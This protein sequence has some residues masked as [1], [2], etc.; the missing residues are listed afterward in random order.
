M[1]GEEG[2]GEGSLKGVNG[3]MEIEIETE[4]ETEIAVEE[5][6]LS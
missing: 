3:E 4:T 5:V 1:K 6:L 2:V